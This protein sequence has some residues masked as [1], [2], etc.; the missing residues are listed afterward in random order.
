MN[1]QRMLGKSE[2][3]SFR[4]LHDA[5][6]SFLRRT[7]SL[8]ALCLFCVINIFAQNVKV[9]GRVTDEAEEAI[10]GAAIKVVDSTIGTISD[11]DGNFVL[12]VPKR[13]TIEISYVG[14]A[15]KRI[16]VTEDKAYAI[17][18]K[19]DTKLLD[20]VIVTGYGAVS[21]KNLTTSIV[22]VKADEV[23]KAA[24]SNMSQMLL[25]R[26]AGLQ[27]TVAS[28]QPGGGINISIRGAGEPIYVVDGMVMPGSA[29]EGDSGGSTTVMP[30]S[31]NRSGL[32]GLNPEDIESIEVLKDASAS[33]YGTVRP[34][35][36]Y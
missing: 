6:Q 7:Y 24:T 36:W 1:E 15:P 26:A 14:Y 33:I 13:A 25:G 20:E 35:V 28:A 5:K 23:N 19:E 31:V 29:L 17:V 12:D 4:L 27:A 34:M 30:S 8:M 18:L 10:I 32:A 11:Y 2:I 9:T 21:K 16:Q 22:K 3:Q